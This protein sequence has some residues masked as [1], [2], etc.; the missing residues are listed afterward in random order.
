METLVWL[1]GDHFKTPAGF[2]T[3]KPLPGEALLSELP[4]LSLTD[5]FRAVYQGKL[6][7]AQAQA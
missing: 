4:S 1:E 7:I 5:P 6:A 3:S 2:I